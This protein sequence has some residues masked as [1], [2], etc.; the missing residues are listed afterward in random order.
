MNLHFF[1]GADEV[2]ASSTLI[3]IEESRILVD[4]G[5]RMGPGQDSQLPDFS[6]FDK[7]GMPDAVLLTHAH[8]DHTGALPVLRN[9][10][11]AGVKIYWT[12]ATRAITRV[13]LEHN[14][15][16][17]RRKEQEKGQVPLYTRDD[18]EVV[19]H[20]MEKEVSW[21]KPEPICGDV[22]ATWIPAG[23]ILGAGMIYL[24]GKSESILVTG[25]VSV[26]AQ[27]TVPGVNHALLSCKPD[28]MVME[29]TYGNSLHKK[30]RTRETNRL[31]RD[32]DKA[33]AAGGKV[34]IPVFSVGRAQEVILILKH[35]LERKKIGKRCPVYVD[36][37]VQDINKIYSDF[38]DELPKSLRRKV[39]R[40]KGLFYSDAIRPIRSNEERNRILSGEPCVIIASSGMLIGGRSS[41]YAKRLATNPKNLIAITGYQAEDTPGCTL[42]NLPKVG[43]WTVG[44]WK[45]DGETSVSVR[46]RVKKYSLSAHAD[47]DQ[48]VKLAQRVSPPTVFLVHGCE[49]GRK[50]LKASIQEELPCVNV[51]LPKNGEV[52]HAGIA[53]GRQLSGER[54]LSEVFAFVEKMEWNGPF[55][56]S[57]LAE[58]WF[59]TNGVTPI[60][61]KFFEWCLSLDRQFF[62]R[63]SGDLFHLRQLI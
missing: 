36:G 39:E 1:G 19:L 43:K 32:I 2:G 14:A 26:T 47:R 63:K 59:G 24:Q 52:Y 20:C 11:L 34:L 9:L 35:A 46:C 18:V 48:L 40:G 55:H 33:L 29:A 15:K 49:K 25:D 44:E 16:R 7:V 27:L 53:K 8:A 42:E 5:I 56:A 37:M 60:V 30:G 13:S 3:E 10:W 38:I 54:I 28:V 6:E 51:I 61:V 31:V 50:R 23:H 12:P 57:E 41:Y 62:E 58:I 21:L 17:M 45:L 4:A 22:I